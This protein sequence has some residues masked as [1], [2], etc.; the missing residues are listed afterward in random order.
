MSEREDLIDRAE[1][2]MQNVHD[3]DVRFRDYAAAMVDAVPVMT[4]DEFHNALRVLRSIDQHE[5]G[6]GDAEYRRFGDDPYGWFI[7]APEEQARALW[8][9][10]LQRMR[11]APNPPGAVV[12]IRG[13]R[14]AGDPDF[15]HG[16]AMPPHPKGA[17]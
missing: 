9:V 7:R 6:L 12:H 15:H 14:P 5:T 3:M 17:A 16:Q 10:V 1:E 13:G 4:F 2:A 8:A 11:P